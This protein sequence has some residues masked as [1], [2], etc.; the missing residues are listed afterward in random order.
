VTLLS[1]LPPRGAARHSSHLESSPRLALVRNYYRC[2]KSLSPRS[3][4][5]H[6]D[7]IWRWRSNSRRST[8][9]QQAAGGAQGQW[10]S[11]LTMVDASPGAGSPELGTP[12]TPAGGRRQ[13]PRPWRPQPLPPPPPQRSATGHG[14]RAAMEAGVGL[15]GGGRRCCRGGCWGGAR[16]SGRG[17]RE[18]R[19]RRFP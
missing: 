6:R 15:G 1:P 17:A 4:F 12:A 11:G 18:Q 10:L 3:S 5:P 16:G 14:L 13:Q 9:G 19:R 2:Q 7:P 8:E